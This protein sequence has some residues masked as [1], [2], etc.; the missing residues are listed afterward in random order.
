MLCQNLIRFAFDFKNLAGGN[1]NFH[2]L[3]LYL[4][5]NLVKTHFEFGKDKSFLFA[6]ANKTAPIE[7]AM[8]TQIV[9]TSI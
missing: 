4:P 9:E 3:S 1:F 6:G 8:P 2:R 5:H 7:A